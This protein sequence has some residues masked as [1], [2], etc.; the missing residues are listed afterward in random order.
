MICAEAG[1][2]IVWPAFKAMSEKVAVSANCDS[3]VVTQL[4]LDEEAIAMQR[5]N[6]QLLQGGS[7]TAIENADQT[8]R[9]VYSGMNGVLATLSSEMV[10]CKALNGFS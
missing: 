5:T 2:S 7:S 4:I 3:S 6:Q 10:R 1:A 8:I 9:S